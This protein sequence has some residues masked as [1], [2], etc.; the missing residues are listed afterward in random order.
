MYKELVQIR[1]WP[2]HGLKVEG[3]GEAGVRIGAFTQRVVAIRVLI[4]TIAAALLM[5]CRHIQYKI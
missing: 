3:L 2:K 4:T 1:T 5:Q